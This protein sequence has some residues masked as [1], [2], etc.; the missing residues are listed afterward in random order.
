MLA[1]AGVCVW[2]VKIGTVSVCVCV[3]VP[4]CVCFSGWTSD[5]S[6]VLEPDEGLSMALG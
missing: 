1:L 6:L 4:E 5:R 3:C 2:F